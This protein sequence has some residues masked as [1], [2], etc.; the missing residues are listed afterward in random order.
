MIMLV[1]LSKV[2]IFKR[3]NLHNFGLVLHY[4]HI[5][6]KQNPMGVR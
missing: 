5:F 2:L 3:K 1:H 6:K 4:S